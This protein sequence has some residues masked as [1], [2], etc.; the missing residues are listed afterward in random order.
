M[1]FSL[2]VVNG[3]FQIEKRS[4]LAHTNPSGKENI[5]FPELRTYL[6]IN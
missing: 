4:Y 3:F 1:Y 5:D 6:Q 2:K